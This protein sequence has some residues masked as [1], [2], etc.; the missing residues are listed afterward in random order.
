[1]QF[2]TPLYS[3]RLTERVSMVL[4]DAC[5]DSGDL[6]TAYC[7]N[8]SKMKG[9]CV[10]GTQI[11]VSE[12]TKK[13][14]YIPFVWEIADVN[15][16]LVGVNMARHYDLVLEAIRNGVMTELAG[17][18]KSER[19]L[20]SSETSLLDIRLTPKQGDDKPLCKVAISSV[21]EKKGVD[22]TYP[23]TIYVANSRIADQMEESLDKGERVVLLLLA[24]RIDSIGVRANW[25]ADPVYINR[26]KNLCDK[27]LE[28]LC[29]GCTVTLK[30]IV[31]TARLPF[32]FDKV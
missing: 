15:G 23:D 19:I 8:V 5:F 22:L 24:Q 27:G 12:N 20:P 13:G 4:A 1:M 25:T 17:Y 21:Y 26:L 3:A 29:Y 2:E 9:L 14:H 16:S 11:Y 6:F 30:E 31:V 32:F 18:E 7:S 28:I 10:P